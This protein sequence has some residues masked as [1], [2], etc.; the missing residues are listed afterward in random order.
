MWD[1]VITSSPAPPQ[2]KICQWWLGNRHP[3]SIYYH[4]HGLPPPSPYYT[5]AHLI[6]DLLYKHKIPHAHHPSPTHPTAR[7]LQIFLLTSNMICKPSVSSWT[8]LQWPWLYQWT[9]QLHSFTIVSGRF[10]NGGRP[11][12]LSKPWELKIHCYFIN[13]FTDIFQ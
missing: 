9:I 8:L 11:R 6:M 1:N 3:W 2:I 12:N 10:V 7:Y 13:Y 4:H 5:H